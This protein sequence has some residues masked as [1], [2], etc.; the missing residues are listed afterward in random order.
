MTDYRVLT[1]LYCA[2]IVKIK[3]FRRPPLHSGRD[4]FARLVLAKA[5]RSGGTDRFATV[6]TDARGGYDH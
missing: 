2:E 3:R 5:S 6:A 4:S 1:V